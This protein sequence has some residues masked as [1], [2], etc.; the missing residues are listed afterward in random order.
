M[1][2]PAEWL[3]KGG[4]LLCLDGF[5]YADEDPW[6]IN[7]WIAWGRALD[8]GTLSLLLTTQRIPPLRSDIECQPVAG[9]ALSDAGELLACRGIALREAALVAL[10]A[11]TEGNPG[12]LCLAAVE[13]RGGG[14][15]ASA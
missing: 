15:P 9:L 1:D 6:L 3:P 12:V 4:Y 11:A 14:R 7:C 13:L 10:H 8:A 5:Q 2:D